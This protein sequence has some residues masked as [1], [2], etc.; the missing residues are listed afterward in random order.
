VQNRIFTCEIFV[1]SDCPELL[2]FLGKTRI[3]GYQSQAALA[4]PTGAR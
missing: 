4:A 2:N 1:H 3:A